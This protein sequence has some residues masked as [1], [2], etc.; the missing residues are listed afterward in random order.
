MSVISTALVVF[1]VCGLLVCELCE[2][3]RAALSF[4]ALAS[5]GFVATAL[6]LGGLHGGAF[7]VFILVGLVLSATGDVALALHGQR[8]FLFGLVAFLL[9]HVAYIAASAAVVPFAQWLAPV[10]ALP[11]IAT[12][13]AYV[14]LAPRL[15]TMRGPVVAYM[16]TITI[17]V[18]G[19]IAYRRSGAA[20][21]D[22]LLLGA[23]SFYLSDLSVARDRFVRRAFVNRAWG[24]PAYYAGQ[25][26][27]AWAVRGA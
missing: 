19:A 14:M 26:L 23:L 16:A 4:K 13:A 15:G 10:A 6:S 18:I 1:F 25:L 5:A 20:H 22:E 12:V 11:I 21:G 27:L 24:L 3:R 8:S 17:M 9:G 7:G 2:A